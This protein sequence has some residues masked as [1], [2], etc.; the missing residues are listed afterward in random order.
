MALSVS[1]NKLFPG[2]SGCVYHSQP[3][4]QCIIS[5]SFILSEA[6]IWARG[7]ATGDVNFMPIII[8]II[9][10]YEDFQIGSIVANTQVPLAFRSLSFGFARV[11]NL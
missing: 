10:S 4:E 2:R 7:F 5:P 9:C 11:L 6:E 1:E 3:K 8:P